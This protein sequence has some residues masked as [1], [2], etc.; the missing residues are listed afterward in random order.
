MTMKLFSRFHH[1]ALTAFLFLLPWQ[2]A[3]ILSEQMLNGGKWQY[4]TLLYYAVDVWLYSLVLLAFGKMLHAFYQKKMHLD[5]QLRYFPKAWRIFFLALIALLVYAGLS[6]FWAIDSNIASQQWHFLVMA[7]VLFMLLLGTEDTQRFWKAWLAASTIQVLF[8]IGQFVLQYSPAVSIL[9]LSEQIPA[10][11]GAFVIVGEEIGRVLRASAAFPH[12]NILGGYLVVSFLIWF[13]VYKKEIRS[14]FPYVLL[15]VHSI[16]LYLSFSRSAWVAAVP[17]LGYMCWRMYQQGKKAF[18]AFII[19]I[20]VPLIIAI[21]L[22]FPI[23]NNRIVAD[24]PHEQRSI[25]ERV[26]AVDQAFLLFQERPW[27]GYGVGQ[28]TAALIEKDATQPGWVYQPVHMIP[29]V[30]LV[31]WGIFGTLFWLIMFFAGVC[32]VLRKK[33]ERV[34]AFI[35]SLSLMPL[36]F[37]D[38][39]LISLRIGVYLL[40]IWGVLLLDRSIKRDVLKP[41]QG[42]KEEKKS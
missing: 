31:E 1:L 38:H 22:T 16:A 21:S 28:Y 15:S 30:L 33:E 2:T 26:D 3:Y 17:M 29:L 40:A 27:F 23:L 42:K 39:Y 13:R 24:A 4:G 9:G 14:F 11:G 19:S 25:T 35:I 18:A 5:W 32:I 10:L 6:L 36:L 37:F 34:Y 8:G 7:G 20:I 12:P 41:K